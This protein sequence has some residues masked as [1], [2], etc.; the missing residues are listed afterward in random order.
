MQVAEVD[1]FFDII[2]GPVAA[3][4]RGENPRY[5]LMKWLC[6]IKFYVDHGD[7]LYQVVVFFP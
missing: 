2:R 3:R 7:I 5:Q 4:I 1:E 6:G